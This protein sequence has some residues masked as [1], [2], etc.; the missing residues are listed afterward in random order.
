MWCMANCVFYTEMTGLFA[1]RREY[2]KR[3]HRYSMFIVQ[4]VYSIVSQV[5]WNLFIVGNT[6]D[7][8]ACLLVVIPQ[9]EMLLKHQPVCG[10]RLIG[11]FILPW[12]IYLCLCKNI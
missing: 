2:L 3:Q 9:T 8:N 6:S 1:S 4:I 7:R 12:R 11:Y 5:K 10:V